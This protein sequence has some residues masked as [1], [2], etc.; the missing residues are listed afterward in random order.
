MAALVI[1]K[2]GASVHTLIA[3]GP[4]SLAYVYLAP[5]GGL[6]K[7]AR[8]IA[9]DAHA[10]VQTQVRAKSFAG[11]EVADF[12]EDT[13]RWAFGRSEQIA[14]WSEEAKDFRAAVLKWLVSSLAA[15]SRFQT[16]IFTTPPHCEAWRMAVDR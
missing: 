14:I 12:D 9:V 3:Q 2:H 5:G 13:L 1:P 8:R 10:I 4:H 16:T 11:R 15:G 6:A 7:L